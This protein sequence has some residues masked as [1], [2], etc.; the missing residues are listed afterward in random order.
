MGLKIGQMVYG[1]CGGIFGREFNSY[2]DKRV[3]AVGFDWVVLRDEDGGIH[4]A[5]GNELQ[6]LEKH[7]T[8]EEIDNGS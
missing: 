1:F 5:E 3:E 8:P 6:Q 7:T 2:G 4:F